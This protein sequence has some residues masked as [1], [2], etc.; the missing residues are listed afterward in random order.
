MNTLR[1]LDPTWW[2]RRGLNYEQ[3][4]GRARLVRLKERSKTTAWALYVDGEYRGSWSRLG[5]AK[6][7]AHELTRNDG[8]L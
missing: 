2:C 5:L 6:R 3:Q 4:D 7:R 1:P 8:K